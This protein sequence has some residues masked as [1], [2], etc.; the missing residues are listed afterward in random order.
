MEKAYLEKL[1]LTPLNRIR[2][3]IN[4][5]DENLREITEEVTTITQTDNIL[6]NNIN[7]L[8]NYINAMEMNK[9]PT[10]SILQTRNLIENN[11][12]N[13]ENLYSLCNKLDI[14]KTNEGK[15]IDSMLNLIKQFKTDDKEEQSHVNNCKYK[16]KRV[17][18]EEKTKFIKR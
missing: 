18:Q 8:V 6:E 7:D 4:K 17:N 1:A 2:N 5:N 11:P 14:L 9:I 12:N 16:R 13:S 3:T 10:S 15:A